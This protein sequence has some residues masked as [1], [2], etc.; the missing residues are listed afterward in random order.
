KLRAEEAEDAFRQARNAVD[1]LIQ[2]CEEDLADKPFEQ[3]LRRML[4]DTVLIFYKGFI[5]QRQDDKNAVA[6]LETTQERVNRILE[7]LNVIEGITQLNVIDFFPVV[8]SE[9]KLSTA[10]RRE[11]E[12]MLKTWSS[13]K[14]QL[15]E[16]AIRATTVEA[17]QKRRGLLLI[18]AREGEELLRQ[19]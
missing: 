19:V 16:E 12:T 11:I 7:E 4:L 2:V 3:G 9:L 8:L 10:Q 1:M 6:D 13:H 14:A 17:S 18:Y 5:D 15:Q